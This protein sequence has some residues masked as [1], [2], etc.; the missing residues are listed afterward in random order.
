M[1]QQTRDK[2]VRDLTPQECREL[3]NPRTIEFC[4]QIKNARLSENVI[5]ALP[6][7]EEAEEGMND[8]RAMWAMCALIEYN[9]VTGSDLETAIKDL[10]GDL[11]HF[12]DRYRVTSEGNP[13]QVIKMYDCCTEA[14]EMYLQENREG[15]Q[16]SM[17]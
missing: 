13:E 2:L 7:D 11:G 9:R 17:L 12:L 14:E 6:Q 15:D 10:I 3:L 8:K 1:S 4:E 5:A 16:F